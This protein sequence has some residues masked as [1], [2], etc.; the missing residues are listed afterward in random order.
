MKFS[1]TILA[2][3]ALAA[4]VMAAPTADAEAAVAVCSC[5]GGFCVPA[6]CNTKREAKAEAE[7]EAEADATAWAALVEKRVCYCYGGFCTPGCH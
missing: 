6:G 4:G 5:Y 1:T 2:T 3:F 7:A